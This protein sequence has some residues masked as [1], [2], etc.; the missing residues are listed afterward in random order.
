MS[1]S[2][3]FGLRFGFADYQNQD[4]DQART[5]L[6]SV[7]DRSLNNLQGVPNPR[8]RDSSLQ[9]NQG[10]VL[11]VTRELRSVSP[12]SELL[13]LV[14][15]A[16]CLLFDS[17]M[18]H[19]LFPAWAD[20]H[21]YTHT[22]TRTATCRTL[23]SIGVRADVPTLNIYIAVQEKRSES[24]TVTARIHAVNG[25]GI[26]SVQRIIARYGRAQ[27]GTQAPFRQSDERDE[28]NRPHGDKNHP[29]FLSP[30]NSGARS[31]GVQSATDFLKQY[32]DQDQDQYQPTG[33]QTQSSQ[34]CPT[35]CPG[36]LDMSGTGINYHGKMSGSVTQ[37][38]LATAIGFDQIR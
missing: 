30:V 29:R 24:P 37:Q 8:P 3:R 25:R 21:S 14:T 22:Y 12:D 9:L 7:C 31:S 38:V 19:I 35:V 27:C 4:Q 1:G 32:Q 23:Y 15:R 10:L 13:A 34:Y 33:R 18:G 11:V 17:H 16:R 5:P 20:T 28:S 2:V 36:E 26:V 6:E